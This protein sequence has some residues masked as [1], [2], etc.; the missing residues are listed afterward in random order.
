[1]PPRRFA[2]A[3]IAAMLTVLALPALAQSVED[4]Y[5]GKTLTI[6][7]GLSPGG[8]YDVNARL[9]A[10]YLGRYVPGQPGIVVRNMPGGGGLV[11]ANY[12]ANVAPRDG[13]HMAAPQR[14]IPF[15]PLLGDASNSKFDPLKLNWIGS[16]NSDTSVA[17][18]TKKSGVKTWQDL[19]THELIVGGT[20]V[21]TESVV[22]PTVLRNVLGLKF[23]VI[24]G[25]P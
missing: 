17:I 16:M 19:K 14:G 25:Y 3:F 1:M 10:K 18:A 24:S 21:G 5:R 15:E 20:G 11:M 13:L 7:V 4:F 22:A 6:Y 12:V 9:L 23:K 2:A 8:G